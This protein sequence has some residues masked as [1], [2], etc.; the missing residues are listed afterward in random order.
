MADQLIEV[1]NRILPDTAWLE[2]LVEMTP[3]MSCDLDLT[4]DELRKAGDEGRAAWWQR[5]LRQSTA[6]A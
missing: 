4:S 6:Q 3:R 2:A 1:S 5:H